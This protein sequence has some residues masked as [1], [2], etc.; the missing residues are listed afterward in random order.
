M[1]MKEGKEGKKKLMLHSGRFRLPTSDRRVEAEMRNRMEASKLLTYNNMVDRQKLRSGFE[2]QKE[3]RKAMVAMHNMLKTTGSSFMSLP[4]DNGLDIEYESSEYFEKGTHIN[5]KT[6]KKWRSTENEIQRTVSAQRQ[7]VPLD[8]DL[9]LEKTI[10]CLAKDEYFQSSTEK[11]SSFMQS[12][13]K[14]PR[15]MSSRSCPTP[16]VDVFECLRED[17]LDGHDTRINRPYTA[18]ARTW[19]QAN[20]GTNTYEPLSFSIAQWE[21]DVVQ[22]YITRINKPLGQISKPDCLRCKSAAELKRMY[23]S[24]QDGSIFRPKSAW[25]IRESETVTKTGIPKKG[26]VSKHKIVQSISPNPPI[27]P[28]TS[29]GLG[30]MRGN[31][32]QSPYLDTGLMSTVLGSTKPKSKKKQNK[33]T[34]KNVNS[35]MKSNSADNMRE[36]YIGNHGSKESDDEYFD[37]LYMPGYCH[38]NRSPDEID[39]IQE[40]NQVSWTDIQCDSRT[41]DVE[42]EEGKPDTMHETHIAKSTSKCKWDITSYRSKS[43]P[44]SMR[45]NKSCNTNVN[46]N[47]EA[48]DIVFCSTDSGRFN[49]KQPDENVPESSQTAKQRLQTAN[50]WQPERNVGHNETHNESRPLTAVKQVTWKNRSKM[51]TTT[52]SDESGLEKKEMITRSG[53]HSATV[54]PQSKDQYKCRT[55][56]QPVENDNGNNSSIIHKHVENSQN[57][58]SD[59]EGK[60]MVI[61]DRQPRWQR[62][63]LKEAPVGFY[64]TKKPVKFNMVF[65][66]SERQKELDKLVYENYFDRR[67]VVNRERSRRLEARVRLFLGS[68][69]VLQLATEKKNHSLK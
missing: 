58:S 42:N 54:R 67:A 32:K 1:K 30:G 43:P 12:R 24:R 13:L 9:T 8:K 5:N 7:R 28:H 38:G 19:F 46:A 62:D 18:P 26:A 68:E 25:G 60:E 49:G 15:C 55:L 52:F 65:S 21:K 4:P 36:T 59:E 53:P 2:I 31:M 41:W 29:G 35:N 44:S 10:T 16:V 34:K 63:L 3:K 45:K 50:K 17:L 27:R 51:S 11:S 64:S 69:K 57:T 40:A 6:L 56:V 20:S 47:V 33:D 22:K 39:I 48:G 37:E 61:P 23:G 66:K 14:E